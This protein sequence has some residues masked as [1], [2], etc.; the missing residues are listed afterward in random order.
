M[1]LCERTSII[2]Y[3]VVHH[4]PWYA[5]KKIELHCTGFPDSKYFMRLVKIIV[6]LFRLKILNENKCINYSTLLL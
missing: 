5:Q 4:S 2:H 1:G 3:V 6:N